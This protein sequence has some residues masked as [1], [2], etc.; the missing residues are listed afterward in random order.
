MRTPAA[1]LVAVAGS[2][3]GLEPIIPLASERAFSPSLIVFG[4]SGEATGMKK[5]RAAASMAL[6]FAAGF[7][8]SLPM[9]R[10]FQKF[11]DPLAPAAPDLFAGLSTFAVIGG[12]TGLLFSAR[13]ARRAKFRPVVVSIR[14]VA[15][16][17]VF[18][19][20]AVAVAMLFFMRGVGALG[21]PLSGFLAYVFFYA[22]MGGALG[23]LLG[24]L[25]KRSRFGVMSGGA[26]PVEPSAQVLRSGNAEDWY[27]GKVFGDSIVSR[28]D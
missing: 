6:L 5:V 9:T 1:L 11:F 27:P 19:G 17:G 8:V 4:D 22:L 2:C 7:V 14:G 28:D 24:G 10:L 3:R 13:F 26:L 20:I 15:V 25:A 18:A 23:A 21:S 16:D 12:A